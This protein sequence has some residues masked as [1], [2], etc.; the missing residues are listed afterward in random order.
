MDEIAS[1]LGIRK[2]NEYEFIP[3]KDKLVDAVLERQ[4]TTAMLRYLEI[5]HSPT[6][7]FDKLYNS[8]CLVGSSI[9]HKGKRFHDE[10]H[11]L[12]P[13]LWHYMEDIRR[14]TL[15]ADFMRFIDDGIERGFVRTDIHRD[16]FLFA[17]ISALQSVMS[18]ELLIRESFS[19]NDAFRSFTQLILDGMLT[20]SARQQ[21]RYSESHQQLTQRVAI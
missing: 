5:M 7:Y 18:S 3:S 10:L 13:D 16:V 1:L 2:K 19:A 6:E 4:I 20:E 14:L 8:L 17:Y 12:R 11:R 15:Y 9:S 21:F